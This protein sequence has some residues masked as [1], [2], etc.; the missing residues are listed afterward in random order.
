MPFL[1]WRIR[2]WRSER[3]LRREHLRQIEQAKKDGTQDG[4][5]ELDAEYQWNLALIADERRLSNQ[6]RVIRKAQGIGLQIPWRSVTAI[7][8]EAEDENWYRGV[9]AEWLLRDRAF[10]DLRR[11]IRRE[12]KEKIELF[13]PWV[14]LLIGLFGSIASV[15]GALL[16]WLA[17]SK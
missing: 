12:Q 2:L 3:K 6:E 16:A 15:L 4:L 8:T 5:G 11:E 9:N 10:T 17:W 14:S 7:Q 13:S 1:P